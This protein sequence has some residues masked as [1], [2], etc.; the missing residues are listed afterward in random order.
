M[1]KISY[2][3]VDTSETAQRVLENSESGNPIATKLNMKYAYFIG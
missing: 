3:F 2:I 1:I